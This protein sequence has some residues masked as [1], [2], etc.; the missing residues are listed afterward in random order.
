M[1]VD[2]SSLAQ[3]EDRVNKA[4]KAK[5]DKDRK[6]HCE[7]AIKQIDKFLDYY[8][9][10]VDHH[11]RHTIQ[12]RTELK[13]TLTSA[14][15][16]KGTETGATIYFAVQQA[17]A[18][19]DGMYKEPRSSL[20]ELI[21]AK[22]QISAGAK[23]GN[24]HD[25]GQ[26]LNLMRFYKSNFKSKMDKIDRDHQAMTAVL[27]KAV[28]ACQDDDYASELDRVRKILNSLSAKTKTFVVPS[29]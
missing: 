15:K 13:Q 24:V 25:L 16:L 28:K 3:A 22:G 18:K 2:F 11:V 29:T 12:L 4:I 20:E 27:G 14:E 8:D 7:E 21:S 10:L 1:S 5:S 9:G 6:P 17:W 19:L 23:S 26:A